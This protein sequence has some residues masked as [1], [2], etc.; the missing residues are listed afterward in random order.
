MHAL[1]DRPRSG[2]Q[3]WLKIR[4]TTKTRRCAPR[5]RA[6]KGAA[7]A[8]SL[9]P[10]GVPG[11]PGRSF[12]RRKPYVRQFCTGITKA[13]GNSAGARMESRLDASL[14]STLDVLAWEVELA[15]A[16]SIFLDSVIGEMM[17]VI[18]ETDQGRFVEAMHTVD[19]L[20]QQLTSLSAFTRRLSSVAPT[21]SSVAV[22]EALGDITLG[23]LADRMASALGAE[24]RGINERDEAGDL[25]LF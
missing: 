14:A 8:T 5:R 1:Q 22:G 9:T 10:S 17:K 7:R 25:D 23:A 4:L 24:E 21:G 2:E 18:P 20:S 16:R 13:L 3:D 12:T 6:N 15:G 11:R 19:L